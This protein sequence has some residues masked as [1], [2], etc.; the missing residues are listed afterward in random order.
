MTSVSTL[1]QTGDGSRSL[2]PILIDVSFSGNNTID[3]TEILARIQSHPTERSVLDRYARMASSL[4]L[5]L[6]YFLKYRA[7][8]DCE[9][10]YLNTATVQED[11]ETIRL[12]Y[13]EKGF[14]ESQIKALFTIDTARNL[15]RLQFTITEGQRFNVWGVQFTGLHGISD[16]LRSEIEDPQYL[17]VGEPFDILNVVLEVQCALALLKN[18]GYAAASEP[19]MPRVVYCAPPRCDE[20]VDTVIIFID[21]YRRYSVGD[22]RVVPHD[23]TGGLPPVD[24]DL[25]LSRLK[26]SS[27][28]W[29]NQSAVDNSK[30]DL[31]RLGIFEGVS[32]DTSSTNDTMD[33]KIDY[34][35]RDLNEVEFSLEGSVIPRVNET[36]FNGGLAL[37]YVRQNLLRRAIR[38]S[39]GGRLQARLISFDEAEWGVDG[40]LDIPEPQLAPSDVA[41]INSGIS[42]GV[43]DQENDSVLRSE[44]INVGIN[45]GWNLPSSYFVNGISSRLIFQLN[46]YSNIKGYIRAK[47]QKRLDAINLPDSCN[48][49]NIVD[50]TVDSLARNIY[51]VQVLQG[52]SP[53][54]MPNQKARNLKGVLNRT[55]I[56]GTSVVGDHRNDFFAPTH[57][58]FFEARFDVGLAGVP[59][60]RGGFIRAEADYR[61][62]LSLGDNEVLA[63]RLHGGAIG[64]VGRFPLTPINNRFHAGGANS[65]RGWGA[66]EMLVTSPAREFAGSCADTVLQEILVESRRLLG[67][68]WLLEGS[69][70][71]RWRFATDLVA[72]FFVDVGNAYFRNYGDDK[73]LITLKTFVENLGVATGVNFGYETPA[74]PIRVGIGFPVYN[75]LDYQRS[76]R[77][78]WNHTESIKPAIQFS[79]GHAF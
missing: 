19:R 22:T 52:D 76:K 30:R 59:D 42:R 35:L 67:G 21:P 43:E 26:Y 9:V 39:I 71:Y 56:L 28:Q 29:Y 13:W 63:L 58:Y 72:L 48:D 65:V 36:V 70:E 64:Q 75:P 55:L 15:A 20:Y 34:R 73:D 4:S 61:R 18:N 33:L 57:G 50:E 51:L 8:T 3:E 7:G 23:S 32:V 60:V 17:K 41:S 69:A 40:Q 1:A 74:G 45:L 11:K 68:L 54:L 46:S 79:I 44:R 14:H 24:S 25:I 27:G 2:R 37:R 10:R 62:F 53:E 66:R 49:V 38:L 78:F 16:E 31:Y 47:A 77:W 12:L 6:A 5:Q